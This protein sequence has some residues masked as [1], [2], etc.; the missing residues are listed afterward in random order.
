VIWVRLARWMIGLA[1]ATSRGVRTLGC[2]PRSNLRAI[3]AK[4]IP[5]GVGGAHG[6]VS[7]VEM[8][9]RSMSVPIGALVLLAGLSVGCGADSVDRASATAALQACLQEQGADVQP[10]P[11]LAPTLSIA[12]DSLDVDLEASDLTVFVTDGDSA[13]ETTFDA[14][15]VTIG[16]GADPL[17]FS[18]EGPVVVLFGEESTPQEAELVRNCVR[19]ATS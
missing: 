16:A 6:G 11:Q 12:A 13:A 18:I 9:T 1:A 4:G 5:P 10:V 15:A 14:L 19:D 7:A 17:D 2:C 3:P 8:V